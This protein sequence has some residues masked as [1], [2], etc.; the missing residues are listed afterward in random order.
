MIKLYE[1]LNP[2]I[3]ATSLKAGKHGYLK[4]SHAKA[5]GVKFVDIDHGLCDI[6]TTKII[7]LLGL[8]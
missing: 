5:A 3:V 7:E 4:K 2:D 8:D 6:K 1:D